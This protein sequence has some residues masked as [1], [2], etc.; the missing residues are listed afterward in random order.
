MYLQETKSVHKS[1]FRLF[2]VC[3]IVNIRINQ[4]CVICWAEVKNVDRLFNV[5]VIALMSDNKCHVTIH[6]G[7]YIV[8]FVTVFFDD[9][10]HRILRY[11]S[12]VDT[13]P[14]RNRAKGRVNCGRPWSTVD[15]DDRPLPDRGRRCQTVV[16][17]VY[18][19]IEFRRQP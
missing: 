18:F 9:I 17:R 14:K 6:I 19:F 15:N 4:T 7:L 5:F 13:R 2:G 12:K 16:D 3:L 11:I 1:C 10:Y 8:N